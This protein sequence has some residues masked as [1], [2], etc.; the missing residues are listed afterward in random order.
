MDRW[1]Y[2]GY[3]FKV[4][5]YAQSESIEMVGDNVRTLTGAYISQPTGTR[6]TF[7]IEATFYQ[8]RT[9]VV[10]SFSMQGYQA[11][12]TKDNSLY[13]LSRNN[14]RID[15]LYKETLLAYD[16]ISLSAVD[17]GNLSA[18]F[19]DTDA[20][21]VVSEGSEKDDVYKLS[22][23]ASVLF[24]TSV[25]WVSGEKIAGIY[26]TNGKVFVIRPSRI[27]QLSSPG[28]SL[29]SSISLPYVLGGYGSIHGDGSLL[30]AGGNDQEKGNV[31]YVVDS[32]SGNI[33][34]GIVEESVSVFHSATYDGKYVYA[35]NRDS[36]VV[37]D[38]FPNTVLADL[39]KLKMETYQYGNVLLKDDMG[40]SRRVAVLNINA[41]RKD[42]NEKTFTVRL[43]V[44][45]IDVAG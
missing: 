14:K 25:S 34:D 41:D 1:K 4:N 19:V 35:Y 42:G 30:M 2:N 31:I 39:F 28:M 5:P 7:S 23:S 16:Q 12:Q 8:P 11:I 21:W 38:I 3:E 33:V 29:I 6:S 10:R 17:N 43:D 36:G 9:R 18:F 44:Q 37:Q 22:L 26:V 45:K 27:E 40:I 32:V 24:K 13:A 20:I 15:L